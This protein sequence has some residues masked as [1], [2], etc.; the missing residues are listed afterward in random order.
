LNDGKIYE[1]GKIK[2]NKAVF[3][4]FNVFVVY[5]KSKKIAVKLSDNNQ[6]AEIISYKKPKFKYLE[7][8]I[9]NF[10]QL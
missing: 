8:V 10:W 3:T 2:I 4:Y 9:V 5:D 7:K 6:F 1:L